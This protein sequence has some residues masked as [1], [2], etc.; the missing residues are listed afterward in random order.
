[1]KNSQ[2]LLL[3]SHQ[4]LQIFFQNLI[5][6]Q[7][8][9]DSLENASSELDTSVDDIGVKLQPFKTFWLI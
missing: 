5:Q 9:L 2:T 3:E 4:L 6:K 1:M 8:A 7:E